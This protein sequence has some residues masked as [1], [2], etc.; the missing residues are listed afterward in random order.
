MSRKMAVY[1]PFLKPEHRE[2]MRA[3]AEKTVLKS[4]WWIHRNRTGII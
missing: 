4:G 1:E 2:K 3:A